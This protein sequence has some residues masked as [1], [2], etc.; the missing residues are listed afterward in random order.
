MYFS[1]FSGLSQS[2]RKC[3]YSINTIIKSESEL[4][5]KFIQNK[6]IALKF[7][8]YDEINLINLIKNRTCFIIAHRLTTIQHAHRIIVLSEGKIVEEGTH[9][10]LISNNG[11]YKNLYELQFKK[12]VSKVHLDG[13]DT[14]VEN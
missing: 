10:E 8:H 12:P 2:G 7:Y 3:R 14:I 13:E 9:E 1:R 6:N 5:S 11:I 4:L